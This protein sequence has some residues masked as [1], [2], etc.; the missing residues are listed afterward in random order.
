M[1]KLLIVVLGWLMVMTA[2]K[3]NSDSAIP[4]T[5]SSFMFFNGVP[6]VTY[7]IWLDSTLIMKDLTFGQSTPYREMRAQ[8]Y[9]IYLID[10][11]RPKDTI[12]VGQINLRNKRL[13][14]AYI[15]VDSANN[16]QRVVTAA[17]DDLTAPPA[18]HMKLRIV[19]L[20]WAF[21]PNG[22][23]SSMDLFSKTTPVFRG[24]GFSAV[25]EFATL[26]GDSTYPFNFRRN[27]DTTKVPNQF[28]FK[29]QSGKIY[30]VVMLGNALTS[31]LFRTFTITHN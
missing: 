12:R 1:K 9:T 11:N 21:R 31:T 20:S 10:H 15:A 22:Q 17:E 24:M 29:S 27:D 5:S 4:V 6:D 3:K 7:D 8:L 25:T 18:E 16:G 14:S 2:C 26:P 19:N 30:T 28:P 23:S 13:F